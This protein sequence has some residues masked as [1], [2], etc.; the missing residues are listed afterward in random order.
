MKEIRVTC[1]GADIL[2]IDSLV[3]LQGNLK[4]ISKD[5]LTKL[6]RSILKHGFTAPIFVWK[7]I[8]YHVIDGHQRLKAL[9][10]LREEGY[11]IPLLPVVYIEAD[12][13][14][15]A[16]EK[17]L[18][19]TSQYGEFT[20]EGI[21]EF[22]E[23]LDI[24]FEDVRLSIGEFDFNQ[25]KEPNETVGDDE[26]PDIQEKVYSKPGEIYNLGEHRLM[27]GDATSQDD[28]YKLLDGKLADILVTDPPYNVE[29]TGK[30]KEKLKIQ[31]DSMSDIGFREFLADSF[32]NASNAMKP[33]AVFY[34]WH[35]DS[36]GYNFRGACHDVGLE[37]RQCLVWNKN[38][39]VMGRQDYQW[40]HEPCLLVEW[41][42]GQAIFWASDRKQTTILEV[43]KD[44]QGALSTYIEACCLS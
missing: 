39:M 16:K 23:G 3:E 41:K 12:N 18:Y 29:Y 33:G 20:T 44:H 6:K 2:P 27:C 15:E 9:C 35:A 34:I 4:T 7:G 8:D 11:N 25:M 40:K 42:S 21:Y 10:S 26:A 28:V 32:R 36:E 14:T 30:T 5:N 31:N 37:V 13:E 1:K 38:S 24:N 17:L 43:S 22:V 19:I